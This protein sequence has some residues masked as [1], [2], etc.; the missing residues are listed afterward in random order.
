MLLLQA[1]AAVQAALGGQPAD[2]DSTAKPDSTAASAP[3]PTAGTGLAT[4]SIPEEG[5]GELEAVSPDA[6]PAQAPQRLVVVLYGTPL[7]GTS[8]QAAALCSRYGL[9]CVSVDS[10]L[11]VRPC[12]CCVV[13]F[14]ISGPDTLLQQFFLMVW[15]VTLN[16]TTLHHTT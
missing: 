2:S 3:A 8:V 13:L 12:S 7:A 6:R 11:Q 16:L 10:L 5:V 9:P 4:A 15:C 14:Y 1:I